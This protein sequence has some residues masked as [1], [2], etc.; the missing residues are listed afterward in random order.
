MK[1]NLRMV[2]AQRDIWKACDLQR[3]LADAGLVISLGKMSHLWSSRCPLTVRLD[4]L[5]IICEVLDCTPS[6]L[7]VPER[8]GA[9][10][11]TTAA[12][13]DEQ[14]GGAS[15]AHQRRTDRARPSL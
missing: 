7:L 12:E 5:D 11:Q 13:T 3:M 14:A 1:W 10:R 15:I 2:A 8:R 9:G 6:D 4:D